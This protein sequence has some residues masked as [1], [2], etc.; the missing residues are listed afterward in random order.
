MTNKNVMS[1]YNTLTDSFL[2]TY[3][4]LLDNEMH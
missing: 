2:I 3:I 4:F 1:S